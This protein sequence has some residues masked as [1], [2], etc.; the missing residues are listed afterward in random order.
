MKKINY[1]QKDFEQAL[2]VLF[3]RP[4]YPQAIEAG[5]REILDNVKQHGNSALIKYAE[6]FDKVKLTAEE[7]LVND[8]ELKQASAKIDSAGKKAIKA[9]QKML[10]IF[11]NNASHSLGAIHHALALL[12]ENV[13]SPCNG[14][15]SISQVAL[16]RWSQL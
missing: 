2:Q 12:S 13:S 9:A 14:L 8:T 16:L 7:F 10:L 3:N 11:L 6:K 15:G 1:H 4:S 5:V